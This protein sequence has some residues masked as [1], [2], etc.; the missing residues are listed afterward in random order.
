MDA[1]GDHRLAGLRKLGIGHRLDQ[2]VFR[3]E[4][5]VQGHH[6]GLRRHGRGIGRRG[7]AELDIAG[8]HELQHLRLLSELGARILIDQHRALA[9]LFQFVCKDVAE[10][11]V[12]GRLGLVICEAIMLHLL[13]ARDVRNCDCR[14]GGCNFAQ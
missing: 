12:S 3:A 11:A 7:D 4:E 6:A 13:R 14:R 2:V 9:Q 8:L 1:V 5:I 10:D